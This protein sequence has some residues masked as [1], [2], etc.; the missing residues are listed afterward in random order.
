MYCSQP[1]KSG[2]MHVIKYVNI[3]A[4]NKHK[5]ILIPKKGLLKVLKGR[6]IG[7]IKFKISFKCTF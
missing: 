5:Y 7:S 2:K 1:K 4:T 3:R 6:Y